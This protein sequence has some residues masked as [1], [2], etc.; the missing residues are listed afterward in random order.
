MENDLIKQ[1]I[2][3]LDAKQQPTLHDF[4]LLQRR[5]AKKHQISFMQK[6]DLVRAYQKMVS[7][8]TIVEKKALN[9]LFQ[10]K[11]TRSQ[12]GIAVVS[13]LTKPF[14]CSG[15]CIYCPS[16][17]N[18]PKSYL[19]NEPAVMRAIACGYHPY[20]QVTARLKALYE[21]GH[22]VEKI[23]IRIIGG[24]WSE[25]P[26]NYQS[27][28]IR[29]LFRACNEFNGQRTKSKS[30][31]E[32]QNENQNT[33]SRIVEMSVETRQDK[34]N[35]TELIRFRK[36]GITK[37]ELGVQSVDD[38]ILKLNDRG[39]T[40]KDTAKATLLLKNYGFKVSYQMMLN[41]YGS[42]GQ[43]DLNVFK[44]IFSDQSYKPD[45]LKIYPLALVKNCSLYKLYL[46]KRFVPYTKEEL[47]SVI[48]NIKRFI[49]KYCRVERVIRDIPATNI[50]KGGAKIS[51]LRQAVEERSKALSY[52]CQCIRC[53][54]IKRHKPD[55]E[56]KIFIEKYIASK[57]IEYFISYETVDRKYLYGF[58]RL[59][60]LD[61]D[62]KINV[63]KNSAIIREIHVYGPTVAI[64]KTDESAHQHTG[65]GKLLMTE[66]EKIAKKCGYKKI[67][68]IAGVGV[69][70]YFEKNG[71]N[72]KQ[73]YMAKSLS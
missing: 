49:P 23:S 10:M 9:N 28:Y 43:K 16:E 24:T 11:N 65:I 63:L 40:N 29:E 5:F 38:Q 1:F 58:C 20:K 41:L 70:G 48:A 32:L 73:T 57:G 60:L 52:T 31:L 21:T 6:D 72:L 14:P 34:I 45:H 25:Y 55:S 17:E 51:N 33:I 19:S 36:Y 26:I 66:A 12:S 46:E 39:N 71:Y 35:E 8:G 59:R 18:V 37:V 22:I 67:A 3:E 56:K 44:K 30:L 15:K 47:I 27:W 69:R 53:R 54:E 64:A 61:N 50:V 4:M 62:A 7:S 2:I 13:V 42:D 68:V